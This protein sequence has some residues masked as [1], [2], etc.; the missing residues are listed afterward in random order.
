MQLHMSG[1]SILHI[2]DDDGAALL[3]QTALQETGAA[4]H[5]YRVSDAENALEFLS[6]TGKYQHAPEPDFIFFRR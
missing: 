3:V 5:C 2:E 4:V 1:Q 6:R